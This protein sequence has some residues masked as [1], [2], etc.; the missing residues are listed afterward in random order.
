VAFFFPYVY[1]HLLEEIFSFFPIH[2]PQRIAAGSSL[3][4]AKR[5]GSKKIRAS[6][7][8][9][10]LIVSR[11]RVLFFC[12]KGASMLVGAIL[13]FFFFFFFF[14]GVLVQ[15]LFKTSRRLCRGFLRIRPRFISPTRFE[16]KCCH[17]PFFLNPRLCRPS[18][19]VCELFLG[20]QTFLFAT[21]PRWVFLL[22]YG[23]QHP[24]RVANCF[25]GLTGLELL[26]LLSP[27]RD[28]RK[29]LPRRRW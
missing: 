14:P 2:Q 3:G 7:P 16:F 22:R 24:P 21:P 8:S 26:F 13:W 10:R 19:G 27:F 6:S 15:F 29:P 25:S 18:L 5:F 20:Q 12:L 4:L 11:N 9:V 23:D 1:D 17:H 28:G